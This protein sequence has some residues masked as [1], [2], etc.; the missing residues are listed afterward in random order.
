M[1]REMKEKHTDNVMK[2]EGGREEAVSVFFPLLQVLHNQENYFGGLGIRYLKR[3]SRKS[4]N[5]TD[6][7]K[8]ALPYKRN[9]MASA[10]TAGLM[11]YAIKVTYSV[12]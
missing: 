10:G 12:R 7:L 8:Q 6:L 9:Q 2:R 11:K 4:M 3:N 1:K 5:E